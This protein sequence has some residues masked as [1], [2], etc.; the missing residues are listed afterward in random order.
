[1]RPEARP[2]RAVGRG[3]VV[4]LESLRATSLSQNALRFRS[5]VLGVSAQG[6][7][8]G[9][10]VRSV[11]VVGSVVPSCEKAPGAQMSPITVASKSLLARNDFT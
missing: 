10:A 3:C 8:V 5:R 9:S 7:G 1:M 6:S 4:S 11:V 2:R